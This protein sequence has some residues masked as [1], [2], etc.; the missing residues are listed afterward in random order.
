MRFNKPG[1]PLRG[2]P[3]TKWRIRYNR[4]LYRKRIAAGPEPLRHRSVWSNW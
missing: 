1:Y 3:F 4:S 2:G